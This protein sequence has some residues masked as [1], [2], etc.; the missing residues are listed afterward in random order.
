MRADRKPFGGKQL[1][2]ELL[3]H[4]RG[5]GKHTGADVGDAGEFEQS[6]DRAVLAVRTV[7]DGEHHV[8]GRQDLTGTGGKCHQLA[9]APRIRRQGQ[10]GARFGGHPGQLPVGD[11]ERIRVGVGEHPRT[12]RRDADR[13][14]LETLRVE[15]AQNAAR[16]HA[17]DG[18]LVAAPAEDDGDAHA[19]T[20]GTHNLERLPVD[21]HPGWVPGR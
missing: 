21:W 17:G 4:P 9:A 2:G 1:L 8:D 10:L 16:G 19:A 12:L 5:A 14:H 20:A 6:L 15:V 18:V 3:V 11:R 7:Q 13:D